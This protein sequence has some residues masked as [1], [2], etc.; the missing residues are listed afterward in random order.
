VSDPWS[1]LCTLHG[2]STLTASSLA[3]MSRLVSCDAGNIQFPVVGLARITLQAHT[4]FIIISVVIIMAKNDSC[5]PQVGKNGTVLSLK[6]THAPYSINVFHHWG[7]VMCAKNLR[8]DA[9]VL[10]F[11]RININASARIGLKVGLESTFLMTWTWT[12]YL[13]T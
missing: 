6:Y 2:G 7:E 13:R 8:W 10:T 9:I 11:V 1:D 3:V 12:C 5:I 4:L